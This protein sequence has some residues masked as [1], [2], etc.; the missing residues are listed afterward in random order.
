VLSRGHRLRRG[1][2]RLTAVPIAPSAKA[3]K[4]RFK[5]LARR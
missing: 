1:R 2:Y 3:K 5:L 4:A